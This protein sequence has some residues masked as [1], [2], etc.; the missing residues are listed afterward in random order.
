MHQSGGSCPWALPEPGGQSALCW[1]WK[2]LPDQYLCCLD[3]SW[4]V[5]SL[6][7]SPRAMKN[8]QSKPLTPAPRLLGVHSW[9]CIPDC[10]ACA[11]GR[12]FFLFSLFHSFV[13]SAATVSSCYPHWG[14]FDF[15]SL[16]LPDVS[17]LKSR[18]LLRKKSTEQ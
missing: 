8:M 4:L 12:V 16:C 2:G 11:K 1:I 17:C 15:S 7:L 3:A 10:S 18:H 9:G 5:A 6:F 13:Y 14:F